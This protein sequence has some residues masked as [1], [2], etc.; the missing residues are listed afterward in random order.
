M[1]RRP[2][3]CSYR[4]PEPLGHTRHLGRRHPQDA[5]G[6]GA[7][8]GTRYRRWIRHEGRHPARRVG[9]GLGGQGAE[10]SREVARRAWRRICRCDRRPGP[11]PQGIAGTRQGR[12]VSGAA[13]G[14]LCQCRRLSV[15]RRHRHPAVRWSE[16]DDRH[17]RHS[18]GRSQN[19]LRAQPHRDHR[20]LSRR[21]PA[22]V[23]SQSRAHGRHRGASDRH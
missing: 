19:H 3:R 4:Q 22:G 15:A 9:G 21:R 5:E 12:Q 23:P 17:L 8:P 20:G 7:R 13:Y 14:S 11:A 6:Q 16:S 18:C 2:P 1:G 10:A